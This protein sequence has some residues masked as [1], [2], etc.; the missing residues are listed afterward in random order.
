MATNANAYN[1]RVT[2]ETLEARFRETFRSQRGAELVD[3]LY[4][5]GVIVPVVDF[6]AAAEGSALRSDL[7]SAWDF[8]TARTTAFNNTQTVTSTAGFYKVNGII[9]VANVAGPSTAF[10][11]LTDGLATKKIIEYDGTVN[12]ENS[13]DLIWETVVF[14]RSQDSLVVTSSTADIRITVHSRQIA[15]VYG[16]LTN[17]SGYVSS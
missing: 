8:A 13:S 17:P 15:D 6:T 7:Q 14:V 1:T 11:A 4:A 12:T 16:N 10:L 9:E 5:S 3:D 2:D